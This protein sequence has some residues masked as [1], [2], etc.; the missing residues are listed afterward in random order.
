[1][2]IMANIS[3]FLVISRKYFSH[4]HTHTRIHKLI[5][6]SLLPLERGIIII[7]VFIGKTDIQRVQVI[8]PEF[9]SSKLQGQDL[10]R[11]VLEHRTQIF[12][13]CAILQ[14]G[15]LALC[16]NGNEY[17]EQLVSIHEP[18]LLKHQL[19]ISVCKWRV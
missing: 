7:H 19:S 13:N 17:G 10:N 2:M 6:L 4:T 5:S 8:C 18:G 12:Y 3:L 16:A 14:P 11:R 15:G 9:T 1:M